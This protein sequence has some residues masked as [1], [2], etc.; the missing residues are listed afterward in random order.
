MKSHLTAAVLGVC[1][2]IALPVMADGWKL[3]LGASYRSFDEVDFKPLALSSSGGAYVNGYWTADDD[4][5]VLSDDQIAP[6]WVANQQEYWRAVSFDQVM[7]DGGPDGWGGTLGAVLA[8]SKQLKTTES[9]WS[10]T[11]KASL[12]WF[13][14]DLSTSAQAS[15]LTT[16]SSVGFFRLPVDPTPTI[17]PAGV[18]VVGGSGPP[19]NEP[20]YDSPGPATTSAALAMAAEMDLYVLSLGVQLARQ[21]GPVALS[22]EVGPT[23]NLVDF[24]TSVSQ[25]VAWTDGGYSSSAHDDVLDVLFGVYAA[26]GV[27]WR[28]NERFEVGL[29][30]RWDEVFEDAETDFAEMDLSGFSVSALFGV[31]F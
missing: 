5:L 21:M 30:A 9:G 16:S 19:L 18:P 1:S 28:F 4:Y 12:G 26:G 8:L 14:S 6:G 25:T 11:A 17:I 29:E 7:Y 10:V 31:S 27:S 24:D 3:S 13:S 20:T 2:L 23:L 15:E 22:L